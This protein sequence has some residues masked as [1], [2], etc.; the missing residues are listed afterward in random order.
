[1]QTGKVR[2]IAVLRW[3]AEQWDQLM[4]ITDEPVCDFAEYQRRTDRNIK[5]LRARGLTCVE[6]T[7]DVA[8]F[9]AMCRAARRPIDTRSRAAYA[10]LLAQR[11]SEH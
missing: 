1:M 5:D 6:V 11:R 9:I 8:E 2:S 7:G 3:T 4:A 10:A